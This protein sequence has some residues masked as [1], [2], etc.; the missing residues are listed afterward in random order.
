M[1]DSGRPSA[2]ALTLALALAFTPYRWAATHS[3]TAR[4]SSWP[5]CCS[6]ASLP[7]ATAASCNRSSHAVRQHE[8]RVSPNPN[9]NPDPYADPD[10]NPNP[11]PNP[12][13]TGSRVCRRV[14]PPPCL[15]VCSRPSAPRC[16]R[17]CWGS[18][19][20]RNEPSWPRPLPL[21]RSYFPFPTDHWPSPG[22]GR[23]AASAQAATCRARPD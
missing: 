6:A 18:V 1:G 12:N 11:N 9:P 15:V 17:R 3:C 7:R 13:Q 5:T 23:G 4:D 8:V 14:A 16:R 10:P 22:A 21:S 19:R 20:A 2:L